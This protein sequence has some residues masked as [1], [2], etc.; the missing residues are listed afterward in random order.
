MVPKQEK[1]L[2]LEK[3]QLQL[4]MMNTMMILWKPCQRLKSRAFLTIKTMKKKLMTNMKISLKLIIKPSFFPNSNKFSFE[5]YQFYAI[6]KQ[7]M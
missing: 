1:K 2:I 6:E 7:K 4:E 5:I 3:W